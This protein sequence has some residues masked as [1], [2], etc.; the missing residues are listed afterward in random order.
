MKKL[1]S[2]LL[3]MA[4]AL[5]CAQVA[6]YAEELPQEVTEPAAMTE[7]TVEAVT[8]VEEDV[9]EEEYSSAV[10]IAPQ[11]ETNPVTTWSELYGKMGVSAS[12]NTGYYDSVTSATQFTSFHAKDISAV[13]SRVTDAEGK[14]TALDGILLTGKENAQSVKLSSASYVYSSKYGFG[15]FDIVPDDTVEGYVWNDYF[16]SL[17][18]AT[19][20]DGKTTVGALPWVDYYGESATSGPHYNKVQISLN[21]GESIGSNKALVHRYDAFVENGNLRP[22]TYTVTLYSEGYEP[23]TASNIAV[24]AVSGVEFAANNV[25]QGAASVT[26]TGVDKLPED[27]QPAYMVDGTEQEM[28][29]V[30]GRDTSYTVTLPENLPIGSHTVTV[31]DKSGKYADLSATFLVTTGKTMAKY[32][33]ASQSLVKANGVSD[34]DFAAYLNAISSVS[35]NGTAYAAAGREAVTIVDKKSGAVSLD[36]FSD[37]TLNE[38]VVT[39]TAY[40]SNS[41]AVVEKGTVSDDAVYYATMNVPYKEFYAAEMTDLEQV[42]VVSTATTSKFKSGGATG[43]S[44]GTYNDGTNLCGVTVAVKL[45]A[46][47]FKSVYK[48]DATAQDDYFVSGI[49][50]TAPAAYKTMNADGSFSAMSTKK[51]ASKLSVTDYTTETGYGDYQVTLDGVSTSGSI[52]GETA[53]ILG[54]V[55]TTSDGKSYAMYA[56]ENLWFGTRIPNVEIAWSVKGGKGLHKSHNNPDAPLFYQYDMNGKTLTNVKLLTSIG[57]YDI[58]CKQVLDHYHAAS[59]I[60]KVEA[61]E[62][63]AT[64]N[65]CVEHYACTVCGDC[66]SDAEG[67]NEVT[68]ASVTIAKL[69]KKSQSMSVKA[70]ASSLKMADLAKKAQTVTLTVSEAKGKV[71]YTVSNSKYMS[72]KNGIVTFKKGIP[73]GT[74]KVTVKAAGNDTYKTVTIKVVKTAQPMKV[75]PASKSYKVSAVKKKAQSFTIKATKAQGKVTYKS[76]NTKYVTVTAKGKVTVKK[77]TPKGT[78]KVTVTAAG[79]ATYAAGSKTVTIKVK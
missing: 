52:N 29:V 55:L 9:S 60:V 58:S 57:V 18:A 20:S 3:A 69:E 1:F 75:S 59:D 64:E 4:M 37:N 50:A 10:S 76:S 68:K 48:A 45:T 19:I 7:E 17:Y 66:Y 5:S 47:Q 41:V 46:K 71:T 79:N 67:Q 38:M 56:L 6:V 77:G 49:T 2:L 13:V 33:A 35:V 42:D 78:Y 26:V 21:S 39:A 72:V 51:D 16:A 23:L 73:A 11:S 27:F 54:A 63:T 32:D 12:Q 53:T 40:T 25:A 62:A 34:A 15:E 24:K 44:Q 61:K 36:K 70:S 74:Y 14:T 43:L 28:K 31:T 30:T 65:G 8:E 22:G